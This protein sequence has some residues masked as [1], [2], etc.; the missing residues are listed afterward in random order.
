MNSKI[1]AEDLVSRQI[2]N[3]ASMDEKLI[4]DANEV[5]RQAAELVK[6]YSK[7]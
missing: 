3:D 1:F 5:V 4:A 7:Y 2:A 6:K